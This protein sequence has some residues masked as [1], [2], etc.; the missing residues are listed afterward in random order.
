MVS[1]TSPERTPAACSP[2]A[3]SIVHLGRVVRGQ[4]AFRGVGSSEWLLADQHR[5]GPVVRAVASAENRTVRTRVDSSSTN[6]TAAR[7]NL[8][9]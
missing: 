8:E 7:V 2:G 4:R 9:P 1:S 5:Y 3:F 6:S